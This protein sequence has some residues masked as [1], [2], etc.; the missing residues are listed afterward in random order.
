MYF[1]IIDLLSNF[2][3]ENV[4]SIQF[5][6]IFEGMGWLFDT[7]LEFKKHFEYLECPYRI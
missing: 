1:S 6:S 3:M 4:K 2:P 5:V 7:G